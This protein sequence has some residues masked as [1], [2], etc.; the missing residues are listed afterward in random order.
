VHKV[1]G[2]GWV[3]EGGLFAPDLTNILN[4]AIISVIKF[5]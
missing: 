2:G 3:G 1:E 5:V 4:H